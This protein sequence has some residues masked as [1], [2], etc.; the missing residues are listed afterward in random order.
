MNAFL[1][2]CKNLWR[3]RLLQLSCSLLRL[4]LLLLFLSLAPPLLALRGL[5]RRCPITLSL[6]LLELRS[7]QSDR[8]AQGC[9]R[10][11]AALISQ[12]G[13]KTQHGASQSCHTPGFVL[14]NLKHRSSLTFPFL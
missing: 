7:R 5:F 9:L 3:M 11:K 13:H 4:L 2:C 1:Q 10:F 6:L 14:H 12:S 8:T